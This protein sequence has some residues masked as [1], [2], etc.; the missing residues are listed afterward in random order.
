MRT[1]CVC[2]YD[3]A[4][5]KNAPSPRHVNEQDAPDRQYPEQMPSR[6]SQIKNLQ[7]KYEHQEGT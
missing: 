3:S 6:P 2:R 4:D 1:H 7:G 5:E